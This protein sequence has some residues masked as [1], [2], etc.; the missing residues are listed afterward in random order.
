MITGVQQ[1]KA[2][3]LHA[4]AVTSA[5]RSEAAPDIPTLAEAGAPGYEA[6]QRYG[7]MAAPDVK[8]VA[9]LRGRE[10]AVD[11]L[12]TGYAFIFRPGSR[13]AIR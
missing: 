10:P 12:T 5:K 13:S 2:R 7:L 11:A 8:S 3:R 1:T 6:V 9:D 4:Y